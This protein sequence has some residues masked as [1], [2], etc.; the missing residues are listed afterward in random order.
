MTMPDRLLSCFSG[1]FIIPELRERR[2]GRG[3][4]RAEGCEKR[5]KMSEDATEAKRG[6]MR[7]CSELE[8]R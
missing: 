3:A 6:K 4:G 7:C 8:F 1:Y 2:R 5:C